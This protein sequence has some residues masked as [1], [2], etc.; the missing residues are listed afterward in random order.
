MDLGH[1]RR[2]A[3]YSMVPAAN[4]ALGV[5]NQADWQPVLC[6]PLRK[7]LVIQIIQCGWPTVPLY[8]YGSHRRRDRHQTLT[9]HLIQLI[10]VALT[11]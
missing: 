11:P 1:H 10:Q 7:R 8:C 3:I 2:I 9:A 6:V 5:P 4:R